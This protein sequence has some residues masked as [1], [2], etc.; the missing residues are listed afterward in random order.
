MDKNTQRTYKN[1]SP[2]KKNVDLTVDDLENNFFN[3]LSTDD[4]GGNGGHDVFDGNT[5]WKT[6]QSKKRKIR[7]SKDSDSYMNSKMSPCKFKSLHVDEK[8]SV[9]FT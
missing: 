4:L 1:S 7:S 6:I 3:V 8:L 5:E 9:L 2:G